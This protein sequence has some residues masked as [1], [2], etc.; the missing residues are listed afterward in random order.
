MDDVKVLKVKLKVIERR[1]CELERAL[2]AL[3]AQGD[4]IEYMAKMEEW[5]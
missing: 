5:F 2:E 4:L 3:L 1:V